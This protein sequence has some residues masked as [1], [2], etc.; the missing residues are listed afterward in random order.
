[1]VKRAMGRLHGTTAWLLGAS[2]FPSLMATPAKADEITDQII[3]NVVQ[4]ILQNVRDEVQRRKLTPYASPRALQFSGDDANLA[5]NPDDPFSAMAYAKIPTKAPPMLAPA[6]AQYLYGFNLSSQGDA[7]ESRSAGVTTITRSVAATGA[8]DITK[9]GV[10]NSSD[11]VSVIVTGMGIW[12]RA[13]GLDM[14]T[15]VGA[16]TIAYVNGGFSTDFTINGNWTRSSFAMLGIQPNGNNSGVSYSPNI[17][18]K[19]ELGNSWFVE[20]TVGFTYTQTFDGNFDTQTG[21]STEVHGGVRVGLE[22]VWNGIRVQSSLSAAAFS[23]VDQLAGG[24]NSVNG[25]PQQV[26]GLTTVG[27]VGGRGSGKLNMLWTDKFSSFVEVHG[28]G[29]GIVTAYGASGGLRW[30]F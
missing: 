28:S 26:A 23:I 7:S 6:P 10:L 2:I 29:I 3:R 11:A 4:N 30:T 1:M 17:Q 21:H 13:S 18:Y 14:T 15:S 20:P 16:G 9:I 19:F 22:S 5:S 24:V 12:S 8:I 27:Q 25:V